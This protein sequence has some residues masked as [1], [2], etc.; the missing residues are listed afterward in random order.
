MKNRSCPNRIACHDYDASNCEG[1][2]VGNLIIKLKKKIKGL[3]AENANLNKMFDYKDR[4]AK[5]SERALES[6]C[7][8]VKELVSFLIELAEKV[9]GL[10]VENYSPE[11]C[12]AKAYINRAEK[13]LAEEQGSGEEEI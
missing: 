6:A 5:V 1:C 2:A 11:E 10:R 12:E 7:E 3:Q 4:R 8:D 9:E 13:E